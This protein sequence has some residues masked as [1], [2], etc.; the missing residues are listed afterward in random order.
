MR[1]GAVVVTVGLP[2]TTSGKTQLQ[3]CGVNYCRQRHRIG[4]RRN[5]RRTRRIVHRSPNGLRYFQGMRNCGRRRLR[6]ARADALREAGVGL[7][8]GALHPGAPPLATFGKDR[9]FADFTGG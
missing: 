6:H 3:H 5:A 2:S 7:G 4:P 8:D 9:G 1:G